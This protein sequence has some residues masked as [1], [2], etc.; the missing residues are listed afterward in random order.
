MA[1]VKHVYSQSVSQEMTALEAKEPKEEKAGAIQRDGVVSFP[2]TDDESEEFDPWALPAFK[3]VGPKWSE[4]DGSGKV[5]RVAWNFTKFIL[6]LFLL[7]MF[8]CSLSFLSSAFRLLGGKAAGEAFASNELLSNPIAGLMIGLLAT[9]LVQSSST[10]T[11]V[12]VAM[13]AS[14][15]LDVKPAIP[16]VMGANIGTS[17]TNTLVSLAQAVDKNEF[18]RAFAG[19]VVHDI[20]NWLSVIVFLPLEVVSH[21]LFY[22]TDKIVRVMKIQTDK[23]ANK[24]LLQKIT[25]PFTK[26]VIQLD[27]KVIKNI[28]LKVGEKSKSLIKTCSL[29]KT[30]LKNVTAELN[31]TGTI[32]NQTLE[33]NV[34]IN[35]PVKCD[36]LFSDAGMSDTTVGVILLIIALFIL[37][38]C[39]I[40]IVKLLHSMLRGQ[41]AAVIK[42]TVN[43]D[44]P[45]PFHHL[46]GYF[47]IIIGAGMTILV[48]SSSIFTS[49]LTPLIGVGVVS[50]ERAYPLTL[51]ANIGTTGTGILAALASDIQ[52]LDKALQI[53]L[54]HLFFNISGILLWYPIPYMRNVPIRFAKFLGN[55]T[56]DY[57]WF[58]LAYLVFGFFLLPA[59]V[60]GLS[61]AGWQILLGVAVP[62]LVLLLF[63][64]I[65]N[66]LQRKKPAVLPEVLKD[67]EWAP[68]WTR[69]LEPHDK[70]LRKA[71]EVSKG[72]CGNK[73]TRDLET[74]V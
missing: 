66:I 17:V 61:L 9:V 11:S 15:I 40:C 12:V 34:T 73:R 62:I 30:V 50:I 60:F 19:A 59:S 25:K 5:K 53:A 57:R 31:I 21:Y 18:R 27:K 70:A 64:L 32:V 55:T 3:S 8:I 58:A 26:L 56:A 13:V 38:V 33:R 16:I 48:Q 44:F 14:S 47:A 6:L 71:Y 10:T 74:V 1:A 7:Y 67:W 49:A 24:E 35:E 52:S 63:I 4:L 29:K 46:T 43:S 54:C 42:R 65:T 2:E 37:C 41:L 45:K 28:A 39:L 68:K 51:G 69:S 36:F 22:L 72:R 20:F 23:G